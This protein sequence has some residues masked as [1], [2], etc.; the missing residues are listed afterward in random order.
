[1]DLSL[2]EWFLMALRNSSP[3]FSLNPS[4]WMDSETDSMTS[5]S[6]R[7]R[8]NAF[9]AVVYFR[10][11]GI[12]SVLENLAK[13]FEGRYKIKGVPSSE[14]VGT[15]HKSLTPAKPLYDGARPVIPPGEFFSQGIFDHFSMS[16]ATDDERTIYVYH[17]L[18]FIPP[19]YVSRVGPSE[20]VD[21]QQR[22]ICESM[23][24]Q[25]S[26]LFQHMKDGFYRKDIFEYKVE[27]CK[28]G[29][30]SRR[31]TPG[32]II[33]EPSR[34]LILA[35]DNFEFAAM[36]DL[37]FRCHNREGLS[38]LYYDQYRYLRGD[39]DARCLHDFDYQI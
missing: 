39:F 11:R 30:L 26:D 5:M 23:L 17:T 18:D 16:S 13:T 15:L 27:R 22:A 33:L 12:G 6:E 38:S 19:Y 28:H 20:V 36:T 32:G 25:V 9:D 10:P 34:G 37:A 3:E 31:V 29:S 21:D 4:G 35:L 24:S 1:M 2:E 8:Y 14:T 7:F